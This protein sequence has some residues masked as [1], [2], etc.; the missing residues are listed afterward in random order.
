MACVTR[1]AP[2]RHPVRPAT[3]S[4]GPLT[5]PSIRALREG[6]VDGLTRLAPPR[7]DRHRDRSVARRGPRRDDRVRLV[8]GRQR[9]PGGRGRHASPTSRR[10][11]RACRSAT[12]SRPTSPR[13]ARSS[14][15]SIRAAAAGQ[16][17]TDPTGDG[18]ALNV[19]ALSQRCP[20]LGCR[21][22]PCIEDYWFHCPCHQSRYDRLGIKAAGELFGPAPRGMDR[23]A[24]EVDAARRPDHRRPAKI[25]LGPLPVALGQPG[26]HPAARRARL[27]MTRGSCASTRAGGASATATRSG[28]LLGSG[29]APARRPG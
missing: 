16:P 8:R 14:S 28:A 5:G 23:Y 10:P 4:A 19:R 11:I 2:P 17:G 6:Q 26:H 18:T 22:N 27:R 9:Q 3:A 21:P 12:G 15:W 25:T 24:I 13:P 20:H 7:G 29:A 1:S